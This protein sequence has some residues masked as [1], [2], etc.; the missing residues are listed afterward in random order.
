MLSGE[1]NLQTHL[2]VKRII[3]FIPIPMQPIFKF[4]LFSGKKLEFLQRWVFG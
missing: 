4:E 3:I 1:E 2:P